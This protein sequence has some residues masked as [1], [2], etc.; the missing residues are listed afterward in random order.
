MD[1]TIVFPIRR[2]VVFALALA[3]TARCSTRSLA[4]IDGGSSAA[5]QSSAA[6]KLK[7]SP[8]PLRPG[9]SHGSAVGPAQE[10]EPM[11]VEVVF[12]GLCSFLNVR[13]LHS[14][15]P[16]PSVILVRASSLPALNP[17]PPP[18]SVAAD[19]HRPGEES[20]TAGMPRMGHLP[21]EMPNHVAFLGFDSGE[22][23]ASFLRDPGIEM[24]D[25]TSFAFLR[26]EGVEIRIANNQRG[27]LEVD[28]SYDYVVRK[29]DY[30]PEAKGK[31]NRDL[32]PLPPL[33]TPKKDSVTAF[34]RLVGGRLAAGR[35]SLVEFEFPR[36]DGTSLRG[37]FAE[38][39]T[40]QVATF[41]NEVR[42]IFSDLSDARDVQEVRLTPRDPSVRK[43]TVFIGNV[44]PQGMLDTF[45]RTIRS[46]GAGGEHFFLLNK[47][48]AP[49]LGDGPV[50]HPVTG[51][52]P[53]G[54]A[55]AI[56]AGFCGPGNANGS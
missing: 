50:A 7:S 15:M 4:Q 9:D 3:M 45:K 26:L 21:G 35:V 55:P 29:D 53:P 39:V 38:E 41:G 44:E 14:D 27:F 37:H 49:G 13:N 42:L 43:V 2:V 31:W 48:A 19:G 8:G 23:N 6:L 11:Q 25:K 30:W 22:V 5:R 28:P 24:L 17:A 34:M 36:A 33:G 20:G 56:T 52:P 18:P 10:A 40:Y 16:P 1:S 47:V 32:V 54:T 51:I 12:A 46:I